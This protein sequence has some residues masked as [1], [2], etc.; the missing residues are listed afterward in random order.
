MQYEIL[1]E[2]VAELSEKLCNSRVS[3]IH[4]PDADIL[5][6]K[7]WNGRDTLRLLISA[8][9]IRSRLH[10]TEKEW[11]NP[12]QPPRFCQLL[13]SRITRIASIA[14]VNEDRIVQL[15]CVGAHGPCHLL[16]ELTGI[17]SNLILVD[18]QGMII[19]VLKRVNGQGEGRSLRAGGQYRFPDKK[20]MDE[21]ARRELRPQL[22]HDDSWNHYV[23]KFY[24][25]SERSENKQDFHLKLQQTIKRQIKKLH[26]RILKINNDQDKQQDADKDRQ[27]G[28]LLL[29][30]LHSIKR[31]METVQLENYYSE[32]PVMLK[33]SLDPLLSPQLNA[34]S[35]FKRYKKSRRGLEHTQ[36]RLEETRLELEWLEQL[37]YQLK[38]AAI[39]SDIEEI[40]QEL[41]SAGILKE[42]GNLHKQRTLSPSQPHEATSPSGFK[43]LWGRNN[44][45]NDQLSTRT[46]K[47]GD[48]WF[49]AYHIPGAHVVMQL[50][51]GK[52]QVSE[53][54]ML[55]AA[56]LAAGYSRGSHDSKVEVMFAEA[57]D[58]HKPKGAKPG[59]VNVLQYKTLIVKPLRLD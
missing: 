5:I 52:K 49:H 6:F 54:D 50:G 16:V 28:E 46:L 11:L 33:I 7:L 18:E 53:A 40:A 23:E 44:R 39:R 43:V 10:L 42:A 48:L 3:K 41:R 19:D 17:S 56:A 27:I 47:D 12:H 45:Q 21:D 32:T 14:V 51:H 24:T 38:D 22:D 34:E 37:D 20:P 2:V 58:V 25:D 57:K 59:L 30:N 15:E 29:A 31:G 36:R 13:R 26:K 1:T 55:Y 35:Y 4:Q 9:S 8:E